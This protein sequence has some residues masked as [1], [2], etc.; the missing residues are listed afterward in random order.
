MQQDN[1]LV[2]ADDNAEEELFRVHLQSLTEDLKLLF[3]GKQ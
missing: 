1:L 3:H 2:I